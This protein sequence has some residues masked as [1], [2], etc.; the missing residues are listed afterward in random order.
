MGKN[1]N[2]TDITMDLFIAAVIG[3]ILIFGYFQYREDENIRGGHRNEVY[4][5]MAESD[6]HNIAAA[7]AD[8]FAN[9]T[10]DTVPTLNGESEYL[11]CTLN[12][13]KGQ[14]IAWVSGTVEPE[15]NVTIVVKDGSG[16]CPKGYQET[17]RGWDSGKYTL[18]L[19]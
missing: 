1:G 15:Y 5:S 17:T 2:K 3:V 6:A 9:P 12:S 13:R 19:N 8:Y 10:H 14:N 4:C 7:L 11:G 18:K 16:K